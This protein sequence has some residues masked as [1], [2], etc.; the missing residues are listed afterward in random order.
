MRVS[1]KSIIVT[2]AGNGIGE[3]IA[4]RLAAEGGK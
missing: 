3:G 2:G 1:N 4:K